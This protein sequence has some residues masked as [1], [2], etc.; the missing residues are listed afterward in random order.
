MALSNPLRLSAPDRQEAPPELTPRQRTWRRAVKNLFAKKVSL[1]GLIIVVGV[2][3]CAT[4]APLLAPHDPNAQAV[5][6]K[7]LPP[8]W[9]EG[10]NPQFPLGTDHLGRDILS[11]LIYGARVSL[12]VGL[13]AVLISGGLGTLLGL[14]SGYYGRWLDDV[15]GRLADIQLAFPFTLLAL[16]VMAVLG[17]GLWK[18]IAVLGIAGWVIYARIVRSEV[19]ALRERE[20]VQAARAL[21]NR[22][23]RIIFQHIL[24]NAIA[25]LIV[26]ST[27]EVPRVII[28]ESALTFLGLGIQP[29]TV[30][31]GGML[32]DSRN[33]ITTHWWVATFPGLALQL[34]VLGL[35][36]VGDW[37][38]DTLDPRL[39]A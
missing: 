25:S 32:A 3:L 26:V 35:N 38:R 13:A 33:Y 12:L 27:L 1:F 37:L 18:T 16:A 2:I 23:G 34:T 39:K 4:F 15:I 28:A 36:L 29:P 24:P 30:T 22:D 31:W 9:M 11:R 5:E 20:F 10:A 7:L 14:V 17:P 21:G 19:L 6:L 8:F